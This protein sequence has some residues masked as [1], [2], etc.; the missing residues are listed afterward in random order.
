MQAS[1][2][3]APRALVDHP[4]PVDATMRLNQ[5]DDSDY[6]NVWLEDFTQEKN[7]WD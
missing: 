4:G 2:H 5:D 3:P 1:K 7:P 6:D